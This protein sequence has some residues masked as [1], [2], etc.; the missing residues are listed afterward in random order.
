[1]ANAYNKDDES[2]S[3][4]I[5]G[6]WAG[7]VRHVLNDL[8]CYKSVMSRFRCWVIRQLLQGRELHIRL[9]VPIEFHAH[10]ELTLGSC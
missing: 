10:P 4:F 7:N 9:Y 6:P 5:L 1:M 2:T 3:G 8:A